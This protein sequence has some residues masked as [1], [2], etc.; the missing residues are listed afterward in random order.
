MIAWQTFNQFSTFPKEISLQQSHPLIRKWD[1]R[2]HV[3]FVQNVMS[4][5]RPSRCPACKV[6]TVCWHVH[7]CFQTIPCQTQV[8][9]YYIQFKLTQ[10]N[11]VTVLLQIV[12]HVHST[13]HINQASNSEICQFL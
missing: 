9:I 1:L 10:H 4:E 2:E 11:T 6:I 12:H 13:F 5:E 7:S 3:L 8:H